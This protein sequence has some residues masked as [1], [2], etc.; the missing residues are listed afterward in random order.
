MIHD[1]GL[2]YFQE[3]ITVLSIEGGF[4]M[5]KWLLV[6]LI[7]IVSGGIWLM[8]RP[9]DG[10]L[11]TFS[12]SLLDQVKA[13]KP[14]EVDGVPVPSLLTEELLTRDDVERVKEETEYTTLWINNHYF[15]YQNM[16]GSKQLAEISVSG[17]SDTLRRQT[18][19]DALG[20]PT[21]EQ[22]IIFSRLYEF[23]YQTSLIVIE[24]SKG[25]LGLKGGKIRA[26]R[27]VP[28]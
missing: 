12:Q 2:Y 20:A 23:P 17:S 26:I 15:S 25:F 21:Y 11:D 3:D 16:N 5:K 24:E 28:Q 14:L 10:D 9:P 6:F 4:F 27:I 13:N 7:L 18:F 22:D 19:I 8:V 1:V